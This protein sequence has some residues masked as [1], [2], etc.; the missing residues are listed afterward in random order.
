M[1]VAHALVQALEDVREA[2]AG[3]STKDTWI[4]LGGAAS[5]GF[6]L[7]H[8][9]GSTE[10]LAAYASG[11]PLT[12]AQRSAIPIEREAGTPPASAAELVDGFAAVVNATL[13][14]LRRTAPDDLLEFRGVGRAQRPSTTLG[15]LSHA[16]EHAQRHTGQVV[17]TAKILRGLRG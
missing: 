17:T 14:Q 4:Q 7:R 12:A 6:H 16:A 15:L 11:A 8:L 5:I 9:A 10:R 2:T 1:P 3:L 13:G